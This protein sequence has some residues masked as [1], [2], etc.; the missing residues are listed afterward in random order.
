MYR[1]EDWASKSY[2][3]MRTPK[4]QETYG[5]HNHHKV[6]DAI[7]SPL[8]WL[9]EDGR[10]FQATLSPTHYLCTHKNSQYSAIVL[11]YIAS[12][13]AIMSDGSQHPEELLVLGRRW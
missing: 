8:L 3:E 4:N 13:N 12:M 9:S 1:Q 10:L 11:P 7:F 5:L 6:V 2:T